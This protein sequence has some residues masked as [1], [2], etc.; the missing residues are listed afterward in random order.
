MPDAIQTTTA[1]SSTAIAT[2]TASDRT[3]VARAV[4]GYL[5]ALRSEHSRRTMR[6]A[7]RV[8]AALANGGQAVEPEAV[9]WHRMTPA[10]VGTLCSALAEKYAPTTA[11]NRI[12]ALRGLVR[13]LWREG[14]LTA[15]ER[16]RLLDA[17]SPARGRR[18]PKGRHV[19]LE[20]RVR[21][22]DACAADPM[23]SGR[24]DAAIVALIYGPRRAEVAAVQL[25]DLDLERAEVL[26]RGKGRKE[27]R[28]KLD[29]GAVA[30]LRAW[31]QVRGQE[32]GPLFL[33][34]T[35]GGLLADGGLSS[36]SIQN[37]LRKRADQAGLGAISCHDLRRTYAGDALDAGA[38]LRGLADQLGHAQVQ[39]TMAYDRRGERVQQSV[40]QRLHTP[41]ATRAAV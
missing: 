1:T 3:T 32:P 26:L 41:F 38:D 28:F 6:A 27:R 34:T 24:R 4:L 25:A 30:A 17:A 10:H 19:D 14:L 2:T 8:V 20:E 29:A 23:P 36:R 15:D 37:A 39:T 21:L 13:A 40:A 11:N 33:R 31:V 18:E 5:G 12:N 22:F 35:R 7:L 16:D 9:D